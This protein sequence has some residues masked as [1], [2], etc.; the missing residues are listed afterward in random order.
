MQK[1]MQK[2]LKTGHT[3]RLHIHGLQYCFYHAWYTQQLS[4]KDYTNQV[5][6]VPWFIQNIAWYITS[7]KIFITAL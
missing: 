7:S 2:R 6:L 5:N 1:S 3:R 4:W